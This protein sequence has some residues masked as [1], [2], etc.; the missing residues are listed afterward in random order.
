[1]KNAKAFA[2]ERRKSKVAKLQ[3]APEIDSTVAVDRI[4][5]ATRNLQPVTLVAF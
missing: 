4:L 3:V 2:D 1:M 5:G